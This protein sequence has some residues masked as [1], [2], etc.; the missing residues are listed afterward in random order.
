MIKRY[1]SRHVVLLLPVLAVLLLV[2]GTRTPLL[3]RA[4]RDRLGPPPPKTV[5]TSLAIEDPG[6]DAMR[7]FYESLMSTEAGERPGITRIIHYG[8][9]HVAADLMTG[10]LRRRLQMGFGDA[11]PGFIGA[12]PWQRYWPHRV[13]STASAGWKTGG[14]ML[15]QEADRR[16]GLAGVSVESHRSDEWIRVEAAC[17]Y[18]EL[19]LLSQPGGGAVEVILD[20]QVYRRRVSLASERAAPAYIEVTARDEGFHT[21]E[22]RTISSGVVRVLGLVV[23]RGGAGV[24]YDAL[25]INGARAGRLLA[26]DRDV[27]ADNLEHR[28]PNLIIIAYGSNEVGD[29]DL[30]LEEY[31]RSFSAVLN[32]LRAAVPRASLLVISPPDRAIRVNGRWQTIPRMAA[33]AAVQR[34]AAL[35]AG[36]AF[37]DLFRAMGAA[38]SIQRWASRTQPLAQPDRVH[39]TREGYRLAAEMLYAELMRGY[40]WELALQETDDSCP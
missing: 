21:V 6:G 2:I 15:S 4:S 29:A 1:C 31:G 39:L 22:I 40:L 9:S 16:F 19:Y 26:W 8:D 20:G 27:L 35:S 7:S 24:V 23:E 18:F 34:R 30:D 11:G 17:R 37:W 25:G 32:R 28:S 14:V 38:G 13:G 3:A 33:L 5:V 10:E 12:R 36:A